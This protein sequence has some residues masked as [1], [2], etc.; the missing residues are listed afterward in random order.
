MMGDRGRLI[1]GVIE[2]WSNPDCVCKWCRPGSDKH[3]WKHAYQRRKRRRGK[4][5][6]KGA[7]GA[8]RED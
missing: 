6:L 4:Q 1:F 2:H 5:T 3:W 8:C 7:G